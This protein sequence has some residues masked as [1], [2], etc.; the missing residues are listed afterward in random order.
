MYHLK[1]K[2]EI[3]TYGLGESI[4]HQITADLCA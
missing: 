2:N 4:S 1:E 3:S